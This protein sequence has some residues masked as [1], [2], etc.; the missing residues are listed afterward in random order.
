[1][2]DVKDKVFSHNAP[3]RENGD[4]MSEQRLTRTSD[5]TR[6]SLAIGIAIGGLIGIA[7]DSIAIGF[8]IGIALAMSIDAGLQQRRKNRED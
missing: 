7:M 8:V 5:I 3:Y 4:R 6:S 1:M 2:P